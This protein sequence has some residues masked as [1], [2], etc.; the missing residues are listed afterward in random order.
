LVSLGMAT[1]GRE[2][3][4]WGAGAESISL[5]SITFLEWDRSVY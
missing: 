2:R 1:V 5:M 4:P 3:S